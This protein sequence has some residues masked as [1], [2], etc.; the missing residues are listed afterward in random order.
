[1]ALERVEKM[2]KP[3]LF[4]FL[5]SPKRIKFW[6]LTMSRKQRNVDIS[7]KLNTGASNYRNELTSEESVS[8]LQHNEN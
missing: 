7:S 1:M 6:S 2:I 3:P 8:H 4:I 5:V